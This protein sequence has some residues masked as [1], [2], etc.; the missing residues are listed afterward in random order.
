MYH[1]VLQGEIRCQDAEK[2]KQLR[3]NRNHFLWQVY[4]GLCANKTEQIQ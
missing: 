2:E 3:G 1:T 4:I